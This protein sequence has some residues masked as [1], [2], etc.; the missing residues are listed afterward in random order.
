MPPNL[1]NYWKAEFIHDISA[2][3]IDAAVDGF[4]RVRSPNSSILFFPI[5]GMASRVAP[6]ATAFPHRAGYHVGI[7]A[8]WTDKTS[9][10]ENIA[11]VRQVWTAIQPSATGG[12][13]VNELGEDDGA[14]RVQVAY[15]ANYE[16]LRTIK[17]RYD[18]DNMLCLNANITPARAATAS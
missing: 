11:W 12:V 16:R 17:A 6:N 2:D 3:V 14:D 5:R 8:L 15:G 4:S 9:N 1:Q 13:Y 7:Y 10:A 18:P